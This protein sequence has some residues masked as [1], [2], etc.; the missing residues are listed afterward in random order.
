LFHLES[1]ACPVQSTLPVHA[2]TY[3]IAAG[4][5]L[6]GRFVIEGVAHRSTMS[7]IYWARRL[8]AGPGDEDEHVVVKQVSAAGLHGAEQAETSRWLAR[9]A[10][11]LS[12]LHNPHLPTLIAAFSE[13]DQHYVVMPYWPGETLKERVQRLGP[14]PEAAVL[15]W[16]LEL[17]E[18]LAYLH[19]QTPP[20]IHRDIKPDNLLIAQRRRPRVSDPDFDPSSLD[21][22]RRDTLIL[23]DLGAARPRPD[24]LPGTAVGTPG[25]APPEQYQGFVDERSDLYALGATLH[26]L[27]TGYDAAEHAPFRHPDV[28]GLAP[29]TSA[30]M[31]QLVAD[32]LQL[33]PAARPAT[34][35][36][37]RGRLQTVVRNVW[38]V[39]QRDS[40]KAGA[41]YSAA[42]QSCWWSAVLTERL[43]DASRAGLLYT[44]F[45]GAFVLA[46]D[47][48]YSYFALRVPKNAHRARR[49]RRRTLAV[50]AP[51]YIAALPMVIGGL[52]AGAISAGLTAIAFPAAILLLIWAYRAGAERKDWRKALTLA[53]EVA[54]V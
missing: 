43:I 33:P 25:Y 35:Q 44:L 8:N 53:E 12:S 9:E 24:G 18:A 14:Q 39:R 15:R 6:A 17:A 16:A 19:A 42:A 54:A 5:A 26:Y 41:L 1:N 27:L 23:L 34:I 13:G 48:Y 20:V 30:E 47:G 36:A 32:L 2:T 50:L 21:D 37:V 7:T 38:E 22:D 3:E 10:G 52:D 4:T 40:A 51:L 31:D 28:K 29:D 49:A 45:L 11:P 46:L